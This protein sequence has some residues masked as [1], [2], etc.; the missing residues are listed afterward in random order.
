MSF[1]PP[2]PRAADRMSE[3]ETE[4]LSVVWSPTRKVAVPL[5]VVTIVFAFRSVARSPE[6]MPSLK[7]RVAIVSFTPTALKSSVWEAL[8]PIEAAV[9]V[10]ATLVVAF[11]TVIAEPVE[12]TL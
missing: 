5:P 2:L 7:T 8:L 11:V 6:V 3:K 9:S 1:A 10:C 12:V 4:T